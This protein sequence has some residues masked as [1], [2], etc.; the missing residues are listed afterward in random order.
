M[1]LDF[2]NSHDFILVIVHFDDKNFGLWWEL[3]V[4]D[5]SRTSVDTFQWAL[6]YLFVGLLVCVFPLLVFLPCIVV[7]AG[8]C[9]GGGGKRP[10]TAQLRSID[11]SG[12]PPPSDGVRLAMLFGCVDSVVDI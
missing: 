10:P 2:A 7:E 8:A 4:R 12:V 6:V 1:V 5:F 9:E 3:F 11:C